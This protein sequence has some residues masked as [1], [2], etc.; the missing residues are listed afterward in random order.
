MFLKLIFLL[1]I[2]EFF[3]ILFF[4]KEKPIRYKQIVKKNGKKLYRIDYTSMVKG[5]K[6]GGEYELIGGNNEGGK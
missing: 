2:G 6:K 3:Y 1:L 4:E 5:G